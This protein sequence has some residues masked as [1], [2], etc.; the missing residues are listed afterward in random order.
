MTGGTPYGG[1]PEADAMAETLKQDF[2]AKTIWVEDQSNDTTE[3][4]AYSAKNLKQHGVTNIALVSQAWHLPR[5]KTLF[6]KQ[7]L[8]VTLA[9]T[10]Y[11][12]CKQHDVAQWLPE[13]NA[14]NKSSMAIKEYLGK[15]TSK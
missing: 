12:T 11:T 9:G 3:N 7:G 6:E 1:R 4:A 13:A 14:L 8:T 5:A 10:G 2:H 15:L